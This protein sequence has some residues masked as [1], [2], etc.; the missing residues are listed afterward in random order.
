M[1]RG[2][3]QGFRKY[4][5]YVPYFCPEHLNQSR[6]LTPLPSS[7][8]PLTSPP[9]MFTKHFLVSFYHQP[10]QL[11]QEQLLPPLEFYC[12]VAVSWCVSFIRHRHATRSA[13]YRSRKPQNCP[14]WLGCKRC[15]GVCGAPVQ[16]RFALVQN[17]VVMVQEALGRPC[18]H[19]AKT[20][21]APSLN[22][23]GQF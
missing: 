2:P 18:F 10:I 1:G 4:L 21:F 22:H 9:N 7:S 15:F 20:P 19:L 5:I 8:L 6:R 13:C 12:N 11:F 16:K 23:F 14:K 3:R 17:R